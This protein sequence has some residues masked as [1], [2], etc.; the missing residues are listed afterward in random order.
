MAQPRKQTMIAG[1]A[2]IGLLLVVMLWIWFGGSNPNAKLGDEGVAAQKA[3]Q[4]AAAHEEPPPPP[5]P[6][7]LKSR[8]GMETNNGK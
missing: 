3:A 1:G 8:G 5:P 7:P 4:E 2:V 6:P